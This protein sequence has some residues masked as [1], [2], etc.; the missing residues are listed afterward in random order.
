MR[1]CERQKD[2]VGWLVSQ[3]RLRDLN[4]IVKEIRLKN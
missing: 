2:A 4:D 1:D 3:R